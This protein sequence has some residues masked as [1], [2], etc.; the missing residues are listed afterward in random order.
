MG[1]AI[2]LD[3]L[4]PKTT[5]DGTSTIMRLHFGSP[6]DGGAGYGEEVNRCK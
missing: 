3:W 1:F 6:G 4:P 5:E 2:I